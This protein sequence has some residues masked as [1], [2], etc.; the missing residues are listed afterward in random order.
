MSRS[1]LQKSKLQ[2]YFLVITLY[3]RVFPSF[4]NNYLIFFL[5]PAVIAQ[6]FNP[7]AEITIHTRR[8]T[9]ETNSEIETQPLT[10]STKTRKCTLN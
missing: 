3:D 7:A 8:P 5:I 2:T 1:R 10:A 9:N 6:I 4:L